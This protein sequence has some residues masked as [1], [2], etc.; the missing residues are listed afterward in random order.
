MAFHLLLWR[1]GLLGPASF[2]L[3]V[4]VVARPGQVPRPLIPSQPRPDPLTG[5]FLELPSDR[6][7]SW[8]DQLLWLP[9]PSFSLALVF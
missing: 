6:H 7:S 9:L 3:C 1:V 2:L 8:G 5:P 4:V